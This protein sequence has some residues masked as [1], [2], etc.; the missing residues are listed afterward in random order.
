MAI[1]AHSLRKVMP[2]L[3]FVLMDQLARASSRNWWLAPEGFQLLCLVIVCQ[4]PNL[5]A[6]GELYPLVLKRI[7]AIS[8]L[9]Q[10]TR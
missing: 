6:E 8:V 9:S 1:V 2:G 3:G 7:V 5:Y 10:L 4:L